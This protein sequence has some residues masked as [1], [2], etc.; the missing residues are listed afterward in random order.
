V[1]DG[2]GAHIFAILGRKRGLTVGLI[3]ALLVQ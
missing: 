3:R 1:A 2:F